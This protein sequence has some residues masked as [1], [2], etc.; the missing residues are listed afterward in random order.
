[1][2]L[3]LLQ[4]PNSEK[5]KELEKQ[6]RI[7]ASLRE[8]ERMV[9]RFRSEQTKEI[10]REREQHKRE[11][12]VQN[13]KALMSD[14]VIDSVSLWL[15][16]MPDLISQSGT[17]ILNI[18]VKLSLKIVFCMWQV[19]S[20]DANWSETRRILRKDHRW[21]SSSLLERDEKERLFNEHIEALAKKKKE[22]FRQLLD[23]T[24]SVRSALMPLPGSYV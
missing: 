1:M 15:Y 4:N 13:F 6:A 2:I 22:Q 8:R 19:K 3:M 20:S 21:E 9:Q 10:D 12:A 14:M 17:L 24:T 23:E 7:E 11:E 16:I 5:E 18:N